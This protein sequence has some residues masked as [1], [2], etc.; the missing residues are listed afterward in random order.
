MKLEVFTKIFV[1]NNN[2]FRLVEELTLLYIGLR[3]IKW[4]FVDFFSFAL[5]IL[6]GKDVSSSSSSKPP[7]SQGPEVP[8]ASLR[9]P[10]AR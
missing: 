5:T 3:P 4:D 7:Q 6:E 1:V 8:L 9:L 2:R 10:T